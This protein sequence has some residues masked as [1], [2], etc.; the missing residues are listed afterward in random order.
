M[1]HKKIDDDDDDD[2]IPEKIQD[3]GEIIDDEVTDIEEENDN[4]ES[5]S[6]VPAHSF[7]QYA[8]T[9]TSTKVIL[10]WYNAPAREIKAQVQLICYSY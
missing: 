2:Y 6:K 5:D 4:I 10:S 7:E 9:I 3:E 1:F 8:M